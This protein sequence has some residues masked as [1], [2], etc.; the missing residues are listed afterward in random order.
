[1]SHDSAINIP[2]AGPTASGATNQ[3]SRV[4]K[5]LV[6]AM[7]GFFLALL[8]GAVALAVL[9]F[10]GFSQGMSGSVSQEYFGLIGVESTADSAVTRILSGAFVFVFA[11]AAVGALLGALL[12]S[13]SRSP[14]Q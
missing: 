14:R 4:P 9:W 3:P 12:G 10:Y 7:I 5:I 13:R 1:M 8:T 11:V 6:S 2:G